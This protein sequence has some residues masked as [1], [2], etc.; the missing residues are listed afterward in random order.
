[1][2]YPVGQV[3]LAFLGNELQHTR[4]RLLAVLLA[5]DELEQHGVRDVHA[6][7]LVERAGRQE[8]LAAVVRLL[9]LW[10][11]QHGDGIAAKVLVEAPGRAAAAQ[12]L[13]R[14]HGVV[15]VVE[16]GVELW[17]VSER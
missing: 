7:E 6:G 14:R 11:G 8:H 17:R 16:T 3:D 2:A 1:M 13:V 15:L 12:L 4:V 10:A 5:V 9:A